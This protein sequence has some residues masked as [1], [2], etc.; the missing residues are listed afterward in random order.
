M[1][2]WYNEIDPYAAQW[3]RNLIAAGCI[4]PGVVDERNILD[5]RPDE[6]AGFTQCHF[7]AGIG[8]WSHALRLAGWPDSRP[9]W[10]GSC[11]CQPFST[12]GRGPG[13]ADERHLWPFWF[14][15][16]DQCRPS[17]VFGEQVE[18]AIGHGWLDLVYSDL[19]GAGYAFAPVGI[20]AAGVGAPHIRQRLW[21]IAARQELAHANST[22]PQGWQQSLRRRAGQGPVGAGGLAV[23]LE[24]PGGFGAG[25]GCGGWNR[26]E[27]PAPGSRHDRKAAEGAHA[28]PERG[29]G[30]ADGFWHSADWLRCRDGHWR[31]VE[32]GTFPLA[33]GASARVGRLRAY[34]NAISPYPAAELI[35]SYLDIERLRLTPLSNRETGSDTRAGVFA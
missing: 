23:Q 15:L 28:L 21:F 19:E 34:G 32:P 33:H 3:L 35:G 2:A 27:T 31:P 29:A 22:G 14:H 18:A 9:V 12:A 20:P 24:T 30:T 25:P 11:P 1:T 16:V 6:L 7:F 4:A 26:R 8:V 10:T 17:V 5:V 13:F